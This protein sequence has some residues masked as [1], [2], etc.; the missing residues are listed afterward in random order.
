MVVDMVLCDTDIKLPTH[1]L[2]KK[3]LQN[4]IRAVAG[5]KWVES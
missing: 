1:L 4:I 2:P 3:E 5:P